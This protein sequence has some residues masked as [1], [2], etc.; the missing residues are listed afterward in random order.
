MHQLGV[1]VRNGRRRRGWPDVGR[2]ERDPSWE[3]HLLNALVRDGQ[4][5]HERCRLREARKRSL[6]GKAQTVCVGKRQPEVVLALSM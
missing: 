6:P 5:R 3:M 1:P 4:R 2:R